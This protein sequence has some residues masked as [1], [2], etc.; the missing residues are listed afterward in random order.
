MK[1]IKK[2]EKLLD[3]QNQENGDN[4][5]KVKDADKLGVKKVLKGVDKKLLKS[6]LIHNYE[7]R[8]QSGEL[9]KLRQIFEETS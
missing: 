3:E 8:S 7:K 2:K 9:K 1:K 5:V 6:C 4:Q